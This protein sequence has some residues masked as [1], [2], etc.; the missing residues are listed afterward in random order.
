MHTDRHTENTF[1][2]KVTFTATKRQLKNIERKSYDSY[3][4]KELKKC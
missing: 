4:R 2:L 1:N 3:K